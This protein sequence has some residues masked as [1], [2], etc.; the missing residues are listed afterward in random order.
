MKKNKLL[1]TGYLPALSTIATS[2]LA[3]GISTTVV[4]EAYA[5]SMEEILVTARKREETLQDVPFSVQAL[6]GDTLEKRGAQSL[7]DLSANVAGFTIQNLG[8]GQSQVAIRGISAGQIIRDVPGAKEQV[9]VYYD[10]APISLSLFTPDLD[11]VDTSRIE[12]LRGPQGTL[13]GAGSIG[14][15]VRYISNKAAIGS[16]EGFVK[17]GLNTTTDGNE[18]G[19]AKIV[20]NF[21]LSDKAA[22]RLVA[23]HT[24]YAGWIDGIGRDLSVNEDIN[25]GSR[26]GFRLGFTFEPNDTLTIQPRIIYQEVDTD[27]ANRNDVYSF[28]QPTVSTNTRQQFNQSPEKFE[29]DFLFADLVITKDFGSTTLT[30]ATS[31]TDRDILVTRDASAL[32]SFVL[33]VPFG[34][35]PDLAGSFNGPLLDGTDVEMFTQ[36]FRLASNDNEKVNWLVGLFYSD[37]ERTYGQNLFVPGFEAATGNPTAGTLIANTDELFKSNIPYDL[38]QTAI[39]GEVDFQVNENTLLSIGGRYY[40]YDEDRVL[41]FDGIFASPSVLNQT[42][43]SDGFSPRVLLAYDIDDDT[44]INA[45]ISEGFRLGGSNDPLNLP[46]CSP[47]DAATFGGNS[48][49]FDDEELTNYELGIKTAIMG[50]NGTFNAAIF[51]SEIDNLQAILD[52]GS[53]SSRIIFNVPEAHATGLELEINADLSDA[54]DVSLTGS[55]IESELDSTLTSG[56]TVLAG[57][58]KGNRIPTVPEFQFAVAGNYNFAFKDWDANWS[59]VVQYVGDRITQTVDQENGGIVSAP[60][61]PIFGGA[62]G[63]NAFD[64]DL[65]SYTIVNTR[66]TIEQEN[67]E[68]SFYINNLFDEEARLSADREAGGIAR[69]GYRVN[70]PRTFGVNYKYN[71]SE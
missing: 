14:G 8:P 32:T 21:A 57:I 59:T 40:D 48:A 64:A 5:S 70:R 36:E 9:G 25:E 62:G 7:E 22:A 16:E 47:E 20:K 26:T 54:F 42:T 46:I 44:Q 15:T 71:F 61:I 18:G 37:L 38:K 13:Y 68:W 60:Q 30:S 67:T 52:A 29:D 3:Y 4:S 43:E 34:I 10:E 51:H 2:L 19:E 24:E 31:Y 65:P 35:A 28:L 23:Y 50:G 17:L 11:F 41:T 33:A 58:R 55:Y 63:N 39:F 56:G 53:C 6:T 45:Q 1:R 66:L 49:S 27:G 69:F 12:V